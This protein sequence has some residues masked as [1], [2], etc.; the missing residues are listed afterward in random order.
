MAGIG[1]TGGTLI[2]S[3]FVYLSL[4]GAITITGYSEDIVCAGTLEDPC[5][6]YVNFTANEDIFLYPLDYDPWGRN[7]TFEFDP[8]VKN[9]TMA[10]SWGTGWR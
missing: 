1:A 5:Y 2:L 7:S 4:I 3:Y 6:A 10:R 9:W 8:G